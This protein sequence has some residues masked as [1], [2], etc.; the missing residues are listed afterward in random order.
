PE[1]VERFGREVK[2]AA[3]L[4]H[5]NIVKAYDAERAGDLQLLAMEYVEGLSLADVLAKKGPLP[6]PNACHYVRQAA[7]GLQHAHE[8]GMVHRDL[9]PHNLMLTPKGVVKI[10][11]FGLAKLVSERQK[12][13]GL[14]HDNAVMGTPQYLAPEQA[15]DSKSADIRADIYALGCTLYDLLAGRPPFAG[16]NPIQVVIAHIEQAPPPLEGLRPDVPPALAAL[17]ARML[18]KDP[19]QRPQTPKEVADALA[20]FAK[21]P[22]KAPPPPAAVAATVETLPPAE[23][24]LAAPRR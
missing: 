9:K 1:A 14:T 20:P 6:I 18:A 23:P 19:A 8:K 12:Q 7:L 4:D 21:P 15:T 5:P 16:D 2:A 10:L 11:D 3:K 24:V 22:R 17:V 13:G